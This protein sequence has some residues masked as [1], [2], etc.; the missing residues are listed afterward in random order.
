MIFN[1]L[2]PDRRAFEGNVPFYI[3]VSQYSVNLLNLFLPSDNSVPAIEVAYYGIF[4]VFAKALKQ[5]LICLWDEFLV[6][7][8]L[9]DEEDGSV[10][11]DRRFG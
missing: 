1:K 5:L 2:V 10:D 8:A 9:T 7:A 6:V 11:H 4:I 3:K